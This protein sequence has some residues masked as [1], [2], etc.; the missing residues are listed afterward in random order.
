MQAPVVELRSGS[1]AVPIPPGGA[2]LLA[3][4]ASAAALRAE[5]AVGAQVT[6]TLSFKPDWPGIVSAVGGGG[7]NLLAPNARASF[8]AIAPKPR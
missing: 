5:A 7:P 4:N 2:V 8:G 3:R 1:S 6:V